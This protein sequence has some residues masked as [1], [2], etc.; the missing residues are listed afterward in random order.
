MASSQSIR[1]E[2]FKASLEFGGR[3][4]VL[5]AVGLNLLG[6]CAFMPQ[7]RRRIDFH[8]TPLGVDLDEFCRQ[9]DARTG[10]A[11]CFYWPVVVSVLVYKDSSFAF[12]FTHSQLLGAPVSFRAYDVCLNIK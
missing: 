7:I 10:D 3:K 4:E 8:L 11:G 9:F 2:G 12:E 1:G 6:A 5:A